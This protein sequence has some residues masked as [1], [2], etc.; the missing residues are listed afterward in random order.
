MKANIMIHIKDFLYYFS[1]G[2]IFVL[3]IPIVLIGF[4]F[5][6]ASRIFLISFIKGYYCL[7]LSYSKEI[8]NNNNNNNEYEYDEENE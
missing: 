5:G 1:L 6:Y 3:S 2:L 8:N 4:I 7:D